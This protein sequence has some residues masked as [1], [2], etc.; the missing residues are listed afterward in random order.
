VRHGQVFNEIQ[1]LDTL[2]RHC[3]KIGKCTQ[4]L[5]LSSMV[6]YNINFC[7]NL[8]FNFHFTFFKVFDKIIQM[9]VLLSEKKHFCGNVVFA[10]KLR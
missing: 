5:V 9:F 8:R 2:K 10:I 1:T 3:P 6:I 7:K 4:G